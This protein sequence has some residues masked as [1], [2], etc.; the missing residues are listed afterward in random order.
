L[1][2]RLGSRCS[3]ISADGVWGRRGGRGCGRG[4]CPLR[5]PQGPQHERASGE[6][7]TVSL[8]VSA[9]RL[10]KVGAVGA[11]PM[12]LRAGRAT[13]RGSESARLRVLLGDLAR[14]FHSGVWLRWEEAGVPPDH[15]P[16]AKLA[17]MK[18]AIEE[19]TGT[20][21][22]T[23][24]APWTHQRQHLISSQPH[25]MPPAPRRRRRRRRARAR[26]PWD[27]MPRCACLVLLQTAR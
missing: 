1:A 21:K 20:E 13:G 6:R 26:R 2:G 24:Q 9:W 27:A 15:D 11:V 25:A 18:K 22:I 16:R 17:G 14:V 4:T 3:H 23:G 5:H 8:R 10:L 12:P 7:K 19:S